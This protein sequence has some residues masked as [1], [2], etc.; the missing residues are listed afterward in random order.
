MEKFKK[1]VSKLN[2]D[3]EFTEFLSAEEDNERLKNTLIEEAREDGEAIGLQKGK[4]EI[5][6]NLLGLQMK[7]SDIAKVTGLTEEE[8]LALNK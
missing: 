2:D 5:A 7:I 3:I 1:E 6:R 4:K 8:I